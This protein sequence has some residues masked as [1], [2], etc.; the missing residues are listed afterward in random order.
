M[1]QQGENSTLSARNNL[2]LESAIRKRKQFGSRK[3]KLQNYSV[4]GR[5]AI[6]KHLKNIFNSNELEENSVMFHFGTNCCGRQNL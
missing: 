2:K 5:Q 6:T 3:H 4:T 1:E